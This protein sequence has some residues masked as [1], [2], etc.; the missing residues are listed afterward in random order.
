M[1]YIDK[2][3]PILVTGVSGYIASWVAKYLVDDGYQVHGT[4][5]SLSDPDKVA[6]LQKIDREGSGTLKLFEADLLAP[7]SFID[8][9]EGCGLVIHLASPFMIQHVK[10]PERQLI[11][12]AVEGTK[13][14]LETVNKTETVK[15]VVLTSSVVAI[16]GDAID[17]RETKDGVFTESH[18]NTTSSA[19]HQPYSYS[20]TLAEKEAWDIAGKQGRW[21]LVTINPGFVMGPS[22]S[23]RIDATSIDFMLSMVNGKYRTGVPDLYFAFVDVR[24]VARAHINAGFIAKASG[25]HIL[26]NDV[27]NVLDMADMLREKYHKKYK[28]PKNTLP[29]FLVYLAGPFQGFTW[30]YL[31]RNLGISYK[32]DNAYSKS[33]L[34]MEYRQ[35]SETFADH[36]AQLD[37]DG[38]I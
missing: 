30:K 17:V 27:K 31:K 33:D 13:N 7:N 15:R 20:K 38:L 18:W 34:G 28:I 36:V 22:L 1:G 8:A 3:K 23:K 29:D 11:K 5:R 26:V 10:D 9:M 25:R 35:I 16:F 32:F 2:N 14:V 6:H 4:V 37:Q 12:P 21:D 19:D 24:D